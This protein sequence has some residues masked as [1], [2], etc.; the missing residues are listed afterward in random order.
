[1]LDCPEGLPKPYTIANFQCLLKVTFIALSHAS[2][3]FL[4][5]VEDI[6]VVF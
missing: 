1:M 3:C 5:W 2:F 6:L 4:S